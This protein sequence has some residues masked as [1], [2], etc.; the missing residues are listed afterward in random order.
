MFSQGSI[1]AGNVS[2]VTLRSLRVP[3]LKDRAGP[4]PLNWCLKRLLEPLLTRS[5]IHLTQKGTFIQLQWVTKKKLHETRRLRASQFLSL[6][7]AEKVSGVQ[8]FSGLLNGMSLGEWHTQDPEAGNSRTSFYLGGEASKSWELSFWTSSP[9]GPSDCDE[10]RKSKTARAGVC[11]VC[12]CVC[13]CVCVLVH[14]C[15][16]VCGSA[17]LKKYCLSC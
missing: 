11:G 12:V 13:V 9:V 7:S 17:I 4:N 14:I 6:V 1:I 2:F 15:L 10:Q 5:H 16:C 3:R 8:G